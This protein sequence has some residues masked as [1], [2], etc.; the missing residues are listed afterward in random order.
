MSV[1]L[2]IAFTGLCALVADGN[3]TPGEILLVDAK[4]IGAISGV[5]L[6]AHAPTLVVS[7]NALANPDSSGP[8]RVI[9]AGAG[10]GAGR[11]L[12]PHGNRGPGPGPGSEEAGPAALSKPRG[13]R[14]R[15][16][17][18]LATRND[19]ASWRDLRFV[20]DMRA[21]SGDGRIDPALLDG[22]RLRPEPTSRVRGGA[23]PPRCRPGR[24]R[25]PE[26]G[27]APRRPV[28]VQGAGSERALRQAM[29]DTIQWNL[30]T[31]AAAVVIEIVP[32]AGGPT[33][34][35]LLAPSATPHRTLRQQPAHREHAARPARHERRG[36]GRPPL[37][38][39]L[40]DAPDR[41]GRPGTCPSCGAPHAGARE[42]AS[43]GRRCARLLGSPGSSPTTQT[44]STSFKEEAPMP[45]WGRCVLS[46]W[47]SLAA[48]AASGQ[49]ACQ[50]R[51]LDVRFSPQAGHA[52]NWCWAASGQMIMELLGE[53][54]RQGL[55]VPP[56][57]GSAR[58][59]GVLRDV[60]LLPARR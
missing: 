7:L 21:I 24:G 4:G 9:V 30:E 34:R 26:P 10:S 33:Q 20:P 37:R 14:R 42:P 13:A 31:G 3:G 48:G 36:H 29:T 25:H 27:D 44:R 47:R 12:G 19:P 17:S 46:A 56:G 60:Q 49:E 2:S 15:G 1:A 55:P 51:T 58:R 11:S 18:P 39:V 41:A 16:P 23:D 50:E 59:E 53:A 6:P 8:T 45:P 35:L 32:V 22:E 40:P 43:S 38:R 52:N 57:G 54:P 28:R 5:S